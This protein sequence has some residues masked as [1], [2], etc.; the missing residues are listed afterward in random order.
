MLESL[1]VSNGREAVWAGTSVVVLLL[2]AII[3]RLHSDVVQNTVES[4]D[5]SRR[6]AILT[7]HLVGASLHRRVVRAGSSSLGSMLR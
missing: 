2:V 6:S 4:V 7:H 1:P 3:L 5:F